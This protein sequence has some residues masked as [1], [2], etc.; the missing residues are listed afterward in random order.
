[1]KIMTFN[2]QHGLDYELRLKG[3]R[4]VNFNKISNIIK[5]Y[6]PDIISFNE[7]Y[8]SGNEIEFGEQIKKI[9]ELTNY[10]YYSF[11]KAID[12][13]NGEYGNALLSNIPFF[14]KEIFKIE[15]PIIKDE[16]VFYES[17]I[18]TRFDFKTFSLYSTHFGLAKQE[19]INAYECFKKISKNDN[20]KIIFLGDFN[21]T[22]DNDIIKELNKKY[23]E[24]TFH[25]NNDLATYPSISPIN[26][27][28][29]IFV[30]KDIEIKSSET[31]Q[32]VASDHFPIICD[33][34]IN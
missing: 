15:D 6:K 34:N 7:V 21:I 16:N 20:N 13:K 1:M 23:N 18:I 4:E 28:D 27:I 32:I 5:D 8:N 22:K 33:L 17:R 14:D 3:I 25:F 30:S 2:I 10:P 31:I 9:A 11:S 24:V 12:T 19:Q 26:K 29:Y